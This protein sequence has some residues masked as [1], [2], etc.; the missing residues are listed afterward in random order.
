MAEI[1][2]S[3]GFV[4]VPASEVQWEK[5]KSQ[6]KN[7]FF[8]K[9]N[10]KSRSSVKNISTVDPHCACASFIFSPLTF[11]GQMQKT[12]K[13]V[14]FGRF[15]AFPDLWR[16]TYREFLSVIIDFIDLMKLFALGCIDLAVSRKF[17]LVGKAEKFT[18][19]AIIMLR[20]LSSVGD[21]DP[22]RATSALTSSTGGVVAGHRC[23]YSKQ[24]CL[25]TSLVEVV[26]L[27]RLQRLQKWCY[28]LFIFFFFQI[29]VLYYRYLRCL[30]TFHFLTTVF[31]LA[32]FCNH[33]ATHPQVLTP[34]GFSED[35]FNHLKVRYNMKK[36]FPEYSQLRA[37]IICIVRWGLISPQHPQ[38]ES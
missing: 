18:G 19:K 9:M 23:S 5:P 31:V 4:P 7:R 32:L 34:D 17:R 35:F 16:H 37:E 33:P 8:S 38:F 2:S 28:S 3:D 1:W 24:S 10:V 36:G 12:R 30:F 15:G 6:K 11:D 14:T 22:L 25:C 13:S 27:Q 20:I 21:R 29:D 26:F